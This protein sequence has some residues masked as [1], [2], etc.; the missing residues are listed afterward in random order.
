MY[1]SMLISIVHLSGIYAAVHFN[2][3]INI[4]LNPIEKKLNSMLHLLLCGDLEA[5]SGTKIDLQIGAE[6]PL[7]I[8]KC[9]I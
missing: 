2:S 4:H 8:I 1:P 6:D 5:M 9:E 3:L 7:H